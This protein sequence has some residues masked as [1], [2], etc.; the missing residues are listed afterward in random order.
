MLNVIE[1]PTCQQEVSRRAI[2]CPSCGERIN[3]VPS[4][5]TLELIDGLRDADLPDVLF[6]YA[7]EVMEVQ[8]RSQKNGPSEREI[9]AGLPRGIRA[10]YTLV[11]LDS[12]VRNGGF[13]QWLTHQSGRDI[14]L[15]LED[16][17]LI[18][19]ANHVDMVGEAISLNRQ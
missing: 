1:C 6:K 14:D 9:L 4:A 2:D 11:V 3:Q 17:Q 10:A 13:F 19:A 18:G 15:T 16:L 8:G 12:E 5:I 7:L